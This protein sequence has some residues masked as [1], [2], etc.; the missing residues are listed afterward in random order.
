[1]IS[2]TRKKVEQKYLH[3]NFQ[4]TSFEDPNKRMKER[5]RTCNQLSFKDNA[6][7]LEIPR[8]PTEKVLSTFKLLKSLKYLN[9]NLR[10]IF[11]FK[12]QDLDKLFKS[13][14]H[15]KDLKFINFQ[16]TEIYFILY[17]LYFPSFSKA[18]SKLNPHTKIKLSLILDSLI[19]GQD[20][21]HL[22]KK[23]VQLEKLTSV[24]LAFTLDF[25]QVSRI[26]E[27]IAS[28]LKSKHLSQ[29][30]LTFDLLKF[31][32][33]NALENILKTLKNAKAIKYLTVHF[34]KFNSISFQDLHELLP[35]LQEIAQVLNLDLVFEDCQL[36]L[37]E[38]KSLKISIN[39]I[40]S[41]SKIHA[42]FTSHS[43]AKISTL[44]C[45]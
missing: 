24:H 30:L 43:L 20:L 7:I 5:P 38:E 9:M 1:M 41:S 42:K 35:I 18:L 4:F 45:N 21:T 15:L 36:T 8:I 26:Q 16:S 32:F 34:K 33:P 14:R 3:K 40:N 6:S 13:I 39:S 17:K 27:V 10:W 44:S 28:L 19:P 31:D 22:L 2:D 29:L 12:P 25:I 23:F 37:S 11:Q